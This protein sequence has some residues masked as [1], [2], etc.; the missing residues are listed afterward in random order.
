MNNYKVS[1]IVPVYNGEEYICDTLK[2]IINQD[3]DDYEIIVIDDGSTDS[4]LSLIK[5]ALEG[6]EIPHK[7]LSQKNSGVS[8]TRN[9]AIT[10]SEGEYLVFVDCDDIITPDHL[11][12]LYNPT[13]DFSL[14]R[15][16]K[17]ANGYTSDAFEYGENIISTQDF[18]R[19][20]LKMEIPFN[21]CQ[22]AYKASIIK[23]NN[24]RFPENVR[25][26]EDTQFALKAL[27][28]GKS[29]KLN[30][31]VTY[32]YIQHDRSAIKT[33]RL[34]RF[35]IVGVFEELEKYYRDMGFGELADLIITSRIPKA[36]FGN[37]NFFFHEGYD[38]DDIMEKMDE[39]D[40]RRKLSR[41]EGDLKFKIKIK[42]FLLNPKLYY[43]FWMKFKNRID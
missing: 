15:L 22:L 21:F 13:S 28:H 43:M 26:G 4:S 14:T 41:Y 31:K 20:E 11:S 7:I 25:Y 19:K 12:T 42:L 30:R 40:L 6:T 16:V 18:I 3:F 1:V 23:N 34:Q 39:D 17:I 32:H 35:G 27:V 5:T 38:F 36:I 33:T 2:S 10:E 8:I 9:R 24:I 37:M 29:I